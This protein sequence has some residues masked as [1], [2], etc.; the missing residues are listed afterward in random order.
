MKFNPVIR[1]LNPA[2][3]NSIRLEPPDKD[4]IFPDQSIENFEIVNSKPSNESLKTNL[5]AAEHENPSLD[6]SR[7]NRE[8]SIPFRILKVKSP[9]TDKEKS[10]I[11]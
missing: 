1:L 10:V 2:N 5:L 6:K 7:L 9:S 11:P 3:E 8:I 4:L